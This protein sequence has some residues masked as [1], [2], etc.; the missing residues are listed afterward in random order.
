MLTCSTPYRNC[1]IYIFSINLRRKR[2]K[3][4]VLLFRGLSCHFPC[5]KN[6]EQ[7]SYEPCPELLQHEARVPGSGEPD[8]ESVPKQII[9][10][11]CFSNFLVYIT[12]DAQ[13]L[14]HPMLSLSL[15]TQSLSDSL[16]LG[17][18]APG[19][20][21][22]SAVQIPCPGRTSPLFS[23]ACSSRALLGCGPCS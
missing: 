2:S 11:L 17:L 6:E 1:L 9:L 4:Y 3:F 21:W 8:P 19:L 12:E 16:N 5:K 20:S 7:R 15:A 22:T 13:F 23:Y 18:S 14:G 10:S